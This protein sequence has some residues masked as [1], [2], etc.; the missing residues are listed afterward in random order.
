MVTHFDT[1]GAKGEEKVDHTPKTCVRFSMQYPVMVT[2]NKK[3]EVDVYR[4]RNLE[5]E[6][7]TDIDQ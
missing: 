3:G 2:G 7:V 5:H 1:H 4:T 6:K